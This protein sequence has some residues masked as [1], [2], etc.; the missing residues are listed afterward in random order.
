MASYRDI[1]QQ[2]KGNKW[3]KCKKARRERLYQNGYEQ[4]M[5]MAF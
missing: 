3:V 1:K 4:R 5:L 2:V